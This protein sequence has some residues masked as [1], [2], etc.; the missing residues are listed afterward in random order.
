MGKKVTYV[1]LALL[2]VRT[3]VVLAT[4]KNTIPIAKPPT[5]DKHDGERDEDA[6]TKR[7]TRHP[8]RP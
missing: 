2:A 1:L 4:R 5:A 7:G 6:A 3:T 8:F